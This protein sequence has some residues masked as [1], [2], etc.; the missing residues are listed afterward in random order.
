LPELVIGYIYHC[1]YE[2]RET[3]NNYIISQSVWR[4]ANK[5]SVTGTHL[6]RR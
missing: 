1:Y 2:V 4:V 6:T 3:I 5:E